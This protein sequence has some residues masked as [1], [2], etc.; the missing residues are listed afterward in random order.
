MLNRKIDEY[1]KEWKSDF[2]ELI[3]IKEKQRKNI[4]TGF[5]QK[6][7]LQHMN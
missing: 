3:Y 1:L 2:N 6:Y 7:I 4:N 5:Y